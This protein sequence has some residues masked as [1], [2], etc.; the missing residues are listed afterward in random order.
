MNKII[1]GKYL[2]DGNGGKPKENS[3]VIIENGG[4]GSKAGA[5]TAGE[6]FDEF[7]KLNK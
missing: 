3:A 5:S 4:K 6:L 1:K 2:I 7:A